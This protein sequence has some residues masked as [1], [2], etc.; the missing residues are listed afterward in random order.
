MKDSAIIELPASQTCKWNQPAGL[1]MTL[2]YI[3][4][5]EFWIVDRFCYIR[6]QT[7]GNK[8]KDVLALVAKVNLYAPTL[9]FESIP[10][11]HVCS[12]HFG[13]V[14]LQVRALSLHI[15]S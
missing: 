13:S 7:S 2:F 9:L 15:S 8:R 11:S 5:V 3:L 12:A 10:S 6:L 14:H 1:E 4:L